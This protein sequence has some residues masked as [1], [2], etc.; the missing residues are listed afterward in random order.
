[1]QIDL[2]ICAF[3]ALGDELFFARAKVDRSLEVF[4][5]LPDLA[6]MSAQHICAAQ[7]STP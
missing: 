3:F 2:V 6:F 1:M 4:E 7:K 5:G